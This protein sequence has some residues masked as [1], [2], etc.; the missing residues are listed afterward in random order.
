MTHYNLVHKFILMPQTMK[1]PDAKAAVGKE[2]KRKSLRQ[3]HHGNS[4]VNSKKDVFLEAKK[5]EKGS[6]IC[7]IDGHLSS[8]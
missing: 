4:K 8:Q 5:R 6:P 7:H 3:S 1:I 2:W